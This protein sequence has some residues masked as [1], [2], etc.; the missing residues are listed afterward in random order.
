[1]ISSP[2]ILP[3]ARGGQAPSYQ[4]FVGFPSLL[5]QVVY[6][7]QHVSSPYYLYKSGANLQ[8]FFVILQPELKNSRKQ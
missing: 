6:E 7:G 2:G 1:M 3:R 8:L 5:H 4:A